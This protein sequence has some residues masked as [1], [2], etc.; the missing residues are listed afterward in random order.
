M[1]FHHP[2]KHFLFLTHKCTSCDTHTCTPHAWWLN[3]SNKTEV[4]CFLTAADLVCFVSELF[5]STM[6]LK[7]QSRFKETDKKMVC[8]L[9]TLK[10]QTWSA[11]QT[12]NVGADRHQQHGVPV[13][14]CRQPLAGGPHGETSHSF[15]LGDQVSVALRQFVLR[16]HLLCRTTWEL[17][18]YSQQQWP[19]HGGYPTVFSQRVW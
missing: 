2:S 7:W 5:I 8:V 4:G 14:V 11:V 15:L 18:L 16:H 12:A 10:F 6:W 3:I 13:S 19:P 17:W 9:R 1:L